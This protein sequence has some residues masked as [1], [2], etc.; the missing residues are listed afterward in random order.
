M[1]CLYTFFSLSTF[2][3]IARDAICDGDLN[4]IRPIIKFTLMGR[5][6]RYTC[7]MNLMYCCAVRYCGR[8]YLHRI[9]NCE[10]H[11]VNSLIYDSIIGTAAAA[12]AALALY[13]IKFQVMF[14]NVVMQIKMI[15]RNK[16]LSAPHFSNC[17]ILQSR[18]SISFVKCQLLLQLLN[19]KLIKKIEKK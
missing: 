4:N 6:F 12:A 13:S 15:S 16:R 2:E 14:I 3:N 10:N 8:V 17:D 9:L 5:C 7:S 11:A 1:S 19:A 18:Q